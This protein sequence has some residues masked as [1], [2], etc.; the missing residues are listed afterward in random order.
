MRN[1]QYLRKD[2]CRVKIQKQLANIIKIIKMTS[3]L[4]GLAEKTTA[5]RRFYAFETPK[6]VTLLAST[7]NNDAFF[8]LLRARSS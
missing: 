1:Q 6:L 4:W 5:N 3:A 2:I 8:H 7:G